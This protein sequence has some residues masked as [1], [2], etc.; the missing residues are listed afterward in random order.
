MFS[1]KQWLPDHPTENAVGFLD[2]IENKKVTVVAYFLT[3]HQER[4]AKII[5]A[6]ENFETD[7]Q[8]KYI[9][10]ILIKNL[11]LQYGEPK[12][13]TAMSRLNAPPEYRVSESIIWKTDD[14]VIDALLSLSEHKTANPGIAIVFFD[15]NND[16]LMQEFPDYGNYDNYLTSVTGDNFRPLSKEQLNQIKKV[17]DKNNK[18]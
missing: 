3:D 15:R 14:T 5:V 6:C 1:D 18:K 10:E 2:T 17:I 13:L 7:I 16:P 8:R 9:F 11:R 12:S 4:L